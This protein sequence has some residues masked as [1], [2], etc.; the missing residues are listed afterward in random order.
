MANNEKTRQAVKDALTDVYYALGGNFPEIEQSTVDFAQ[1]LATIASGDGYSE[2]RIVEQ[3]A[4]K[5]LLFIL[6]ETNPE[7]GEPIVT[8]S[9]LCY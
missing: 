6:E 4:K 3:E 2:S 5:L 1:A 7:T 8:D 9:Q